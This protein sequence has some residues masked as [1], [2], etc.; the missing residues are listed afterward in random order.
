[1]TTDYFGPAPTPVAANELVVAGEGGGHPAECA[2]LGNAGC[3]VV[4]VYTAPKTGTAPWKAT[5][6]HSFS[7]TDGAQ[8]YGSF[9]A[10]GAS[11]L[12][13]V[14]QYGGPA[15]IACKDISNLSLGCG[16]IYK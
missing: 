7:Q 9:L 4:A 12:Y 10:D 16:V 6:I 5:V 8:P 3:G 2:L 15:S 11:T 1:M 14:T 13:G